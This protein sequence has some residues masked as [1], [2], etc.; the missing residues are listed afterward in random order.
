MKAENHWL[1]PRP[2]SAFLCAAL[3][4]AGLPRMPQ[5]TQID[6]GPPLMRG[7]PGV[8]LIADDVP[9]G[10][11][12]L[13]LDQAWLTKFVR[14]SLRRDSISVLDRSVALASSR[15]PLLIV[16]LQAVPLTMRKAF[17]WHLSLSLKQRVRTAGPDSAT[18]VATTWEAAATMGIT[19]NDL[20]MES[21]GASLQD[22]VSEFLRAWAQREREP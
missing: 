16:R 5:G 15:Q 11:G 14:A 10:V 1:R 17:A 20:L 3:V 7:L 19:S 21:V 13:G 6:A 18:T 9:T 22:Q 12:A 8:A 4:L 2:A